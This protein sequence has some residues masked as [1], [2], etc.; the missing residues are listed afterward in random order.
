MP[1]CPISACPAPFGL[2]YVSYDRSL[3]ESEWGR[4][5]HNSR[6]PAAKH[7]LLS[8]GS[9]SN[10]GERARFTANFSLFS[11]SFFV[12]VPGDLILN[13]NADSLPSHSPPQPHP[14]TL[15]RSPVLPLPRSPF[16]L[17]PPSSLP[18]GSSLVELPPLGGEARYGLR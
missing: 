7:R 18:D 14:Q 10:T 6:P 15:P 11:A 8:R 9:T 16:S 13:N 4:A 1:L 3:A 12:S 17:L 2:Y 5:A